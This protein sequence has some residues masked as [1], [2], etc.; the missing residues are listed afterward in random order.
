MRAAEPSRDLDGGAR[1]VISELGK[2]IGRR[3][4]NAVVPNPGEPAGTS[5]RAAATGMLR[6]LRVAREEAVAAIEHLPVTCRAAAQAETVARL[7]RALSHARRVVAM[8]DAG[9]GE[10]DEMREAA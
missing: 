5:R 7:D 1:M 9:V 4:P 2:T 3:E 10:D 8:L 6:M